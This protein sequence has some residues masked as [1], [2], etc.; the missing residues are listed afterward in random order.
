MLVQQGITDE[1][2]A[3]LYQR[4]QRV[5]G[6][7]RVEGFEMPALEGLLRRL[8]RWG[9]AYPV[10]ML[11]PAFNWCEQPSWFNPAL[12]PDVPRMVCRATPDQEQTPVSVLTPFPKGREGVHGESSGLGGGGYEDE[13]LLL[14][15]Y[16]NLPATSIRNAMFTWLQSNLTAGWPMSAISQDGPHPAVPMQRV[17]GDLLI[18]WLRGERL[19][20]TLTPPHLPC[21]SRSKRMRKL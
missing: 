14:A 15:Q 4:C 1:A 3:H 21:L 10:V 5:A 16:Y 13:A 12:F 6:L 8:L 11:T 18:H 2:L 7:R 17:M 19:Q 20:L 9:G